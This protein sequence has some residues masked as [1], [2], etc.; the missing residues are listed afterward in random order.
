M[1]ANNYSLSTWVLSSIEEELSWCLLSGHV[2]E[3]D[4]VSM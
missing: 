1:E 2:L 4:E 3:K